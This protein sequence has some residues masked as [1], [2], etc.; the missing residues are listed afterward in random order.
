M[1]DDDDDDEFDDKDDLDGD[2]GRDIFVFFLRY[3]V[4]RNR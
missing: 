2:E 3:Y 4:L 1:E